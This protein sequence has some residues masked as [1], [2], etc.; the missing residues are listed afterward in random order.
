[1]LSSQQLSVFHFCYSLSISLRAAIRA[2]QHSEPVELCSMPTAISSLQRL[3]NKMCKWVAMSAYDML[4]QSNEKRPHSNQRGTTWLWCCRMFLVRW[5]VAIFRFGV[6]FK[7]VRLLAGTHNHYCGNDENTDNES[8]Q[9]VWLVTKYFIKRIHS[10]SEAYCI[11]LN[12]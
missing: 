6:V 10:N 8:L 5:Q 7:I 2:H 4:T 12:E 1:V 3:Y 9:R 11:M